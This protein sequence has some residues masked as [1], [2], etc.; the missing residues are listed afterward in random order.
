MKA[1][2]RFKFQIFFFS[3]PCNCLCYAGCIVNFG[4]LSVNSMQFDGKPMMKKAPYTNWIKRTC[5]ISKPPLISVVSREK[6]PMFAQIN[7]K[8]CKMPACKMYLFK[9]RPDFMPRYGYQA[10]QTILFAVFLFQFFSHRSSS[11]RGGKKRDA[12]Q[13][14]DKWIL[15]GHINNAEFILQ[16][17][18]TSIGVSFHFESAPFFSRLLFHSVFLCL[19]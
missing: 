5:Q 12:N 8:T 7:W 3:T 9:W 19:R 13:S 2:I 11:F 15:Y 17:V 10:L 6:H 18:T 14:F 4:I 1:D 16:A